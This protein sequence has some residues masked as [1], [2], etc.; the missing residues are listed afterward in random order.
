MCKSHTHASTLL[1]ASLVTYALLGLLSSYTIAYARRLV[2]SCAELLEFCI[3]VEKW[4]AAAT[5]SA[6]TNGCVGCMVDPRS[7]C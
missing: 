4:P 2:S 7:S 6:G 5:T 3:D 1:V